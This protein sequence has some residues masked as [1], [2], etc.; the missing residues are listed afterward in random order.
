MA[1]VYLGIGSNLGN[2]ESNIETAIEN[3]KIGVGEVLSISSFYYSE[4]IGFESENNFVNVVLSLFTERTPQQLLEELQQIERKMGRVKLDNVRYADRIID[5][6]ILAF[7]NLVFQEPNLEIP[8][9]EMTNR[10]FV[11]IPLYEINPDF[12]HPKENKPIKEFI[13]KED[14]LKIGYSTK[15]F[16]GKTKRYC[17][18]LELKNDPKLIEMYKKRHTKGEVWQE[19][20][21]GIR[22][23]GILDM[24]IYLLGTK[25][26]MIVETPRQFNWDNAFEKLNKLP[27]QQEW[28]DYMS[29][30]QQSNPNATSTEKWTLME[31]IFHLYD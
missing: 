17:Q 26:F 10:D 16:K 25:L 2:K 7:D 29:I 11:L 5:I 14:L 21:E 15:E 6:D 31:R 9:P 28:E 27:R 8:H 12:I 3:I 13:S 30:F 1:F 19:V 4:P 18:T 23:V 20:L 22:Q 24:E